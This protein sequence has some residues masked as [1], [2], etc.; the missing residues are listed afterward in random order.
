MAKEAA[1]P[2]RPNEVCLD[3]AFVLIEGHTLPKSQD[4]YSGAMSGPPAV[5][6]AHLP[7][8][9]CPLSVR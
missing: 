7:L 9:F 6:P 2:H 4:V 3:K 5:P 1:L 8:V